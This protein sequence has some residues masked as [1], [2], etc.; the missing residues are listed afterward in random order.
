M[1]LEVS[2]ELHVVHDDR[3]FVVRGPGGTLRQFLLLL[4]EGL[5]ISLPRSEEPEAAPN[6]HSKADGPV[7]C[8]KDQRAF[9]SQH[10]LLVHLARTHGVAGKNRERNS[11][12]AP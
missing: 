1:T 3:A 11:R 10:A 4:E 5:E 9:K 2:G 7:L 12:K 6:G 8:P